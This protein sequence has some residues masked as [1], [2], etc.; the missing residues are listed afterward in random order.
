[1]LQATTSVEA[2]FHQYYLTRPLA[3]AL[4]AISPSHPCLPALVLVNAMSLCNSS[5]LPTYQ[6]YTVPSTPRI[7]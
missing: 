1:M 6:L 5:G 4:C 7:S 2:T 3:A